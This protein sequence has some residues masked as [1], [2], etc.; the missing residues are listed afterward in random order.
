M[1]RSLRA[2]GRGMP[3]PYIAAPRRGCALL[4]LLLFFITLSLLT[5]IVFS[6]AKGRM[7]ELA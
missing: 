1:R 6:L 5:L 3:R 2:G 7:F 4:L